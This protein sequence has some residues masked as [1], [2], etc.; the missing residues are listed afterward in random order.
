MPRSPSFLAQPIRSFVLSGLAPL[1]AAGSIVATSGCHPVVA[2]ASRRRIS[3]AGRRSYAVNINSTFH[4]RIC[5]L[6]SPAKR[7]H[8]QV[9][10]CGYDKR[11]TGL[12]SRCRALTLT[13][14][15]TLGSILA[16]P[17]GEVRQ[18]QAPQQAI[19]KLIA[20]VKDTG[21][22]WHERRTAIYGLG[23]PELRPAVAAAVPAL[24]DL[25]DNKN[26]GLQVASA[27]VLSQL[28][29]TALPALKRATEAPSKMRSAVESVLWMGEAGRPTLIQF[30]AHKDA[31]IRGRAAEVLA[32]ARR[33]DPATVPALT[34]CLSDKSPAVRAHSAK[35]LARVG[36]RAA[37]AVPHLTKNLDDPDPDSR[38]AA[39]HALGVF[40]A[41]AR[42][43]AEPLERILTRKNSPTP[44][45]IAAADTLGRIQAQASEP[46]ARVLKD[47]TK[48]K[49][50]RIAAAKALGAMGPDS[51]P[52]LLDALKDEN[53]QIRWNAAIALSGLAES[54]VTALC[55][56]LR[57]GDSLTKR[58]AAFAIGRAA[59]RAKSTRRG[60]KEALAA[61]AEA[62]VPTLLTELSDENPALRRNAAAALGEMSP[63]AQAVIPALRS[64]L[65]D[66]QAGV[67]LAAAQALGKLGGAA[68][69]AAEELKALLRSSKDLKL[70][71]AAAYALEGIEGALPEVT[72]G[73][74]IPIRGYV[75]NRYVRMF[76]GQWQGMIFA[77]DGNCYFGGGGHWK[78]HGSAFFRYLPEKQK[79]EILSKDIT[80]I[81]RED[82]NETPP[83]GKIHS[84][85]IEHNG[86]LFFGTHLADYSV[87][88]CRAYTG[89]HLIGY[90][91]ATGKFHDYGVV[92]PNY[93]NYSG[94]GV[95]PKRNLAYIWVMPFAEGDGS[96]LYRVDLETGEKKTGGPIRR[97]SC[98]YLFVDSRG[99]CWFQMG[100]LYRFRAMT[101]E[102][103]CWLGTVPSGPWEERL[104][105]PGGD[106]CFV[107]VGDTLYIL[108]AA[109]DRDSP[110]AFMP[111]K[112]IGRTHHSLAMNSKR[113][114]FARSQRRPRKKGEPRRR[115]TWLMSMSLDPT[116]RPRVVNHGIMT[117][118]AGRT[119]HGIW[120][121]EV[122]ERDRL[123]MTGRWYV[124]PGEE[125][126]IGV[127]R[128]DGFICLEFNFVDMTGR[129][130]DE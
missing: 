86:R 88:G 11:S 85:M 3:A 64:L 91:L 27:K 80:P 53:E 117:D 39:I 125:Q 89:G 94:L 77:S 66:Q 22:P 106:R 102:L 45:R 40:G 103:D 92:H 6:F 10:A 109:E 95:D 15:L 32:R 38:L 83:Q 71:W 65:A 74:T 62:A 42:A 112:R 120:S 25:L 67:R 52:A 68:W 115:D 56:R 123:C 90:E 122:D 44:L 84:Q 118:Q 105:L 93:T 110:G 29:E 111:I 26:L 47:A 100:D 129:A 104:V 108:D 28:G 99:D 116:T 43:A 1:G 54:V 20:A 5:Q 13:L 8:K 126:T 21:K 34:R 55:Q 78:S 48:E 72:A 4:E 2:A 87:E 79:V 31:H 36:A 23:A 59:Q 30:L 69:P 107:P 46:L 73:K 76:D 130:E 19:Q 101:G 82:I 14:A 70:Q 35:A 33:G 24:V 63:R 121:M 17:G 9:A 61:I 49:A 16:E 119:P 7:A 81:C 51:A 37:S 97:S 12:Y 60:A 41:A 114:Y 18:G 98:Q 127:N 50:L 75:L 57:E 124:L 113:L 96:H 128:G 58:Y